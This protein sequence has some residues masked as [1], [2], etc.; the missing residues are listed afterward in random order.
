MEKYLKEKSVQYGYLNRQI[1]LLD[2]SNKFTAVWS[3]PSGV[4]Q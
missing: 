2:F 3:D 1:S 4:E